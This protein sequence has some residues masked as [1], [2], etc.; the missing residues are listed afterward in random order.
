MLNE[1][2]SESNVAMNSKAPK[3]KTNEEINAFNKLVSEVNK[4]IGNYNKL[5]IQLTEDKNLMIN[6]WNVASQ[7][8]VSKHVPKE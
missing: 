3:D 7:R 8:F 5:N 2:M 6:N 4:E 1:K